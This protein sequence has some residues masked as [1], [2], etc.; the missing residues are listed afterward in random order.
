MCFPKLANVTLVL[1]ILV[2][3]VWCVPTPKGHLH[4]PFRKLPLGS[5][6]KRRSFAEIELLHQSSV[7]YSAVLEM[8]TPSQEVSVVLDTG[9][10][11]LWVASSSNPY[12]LNGQDGSS[13]SNQTYNGQPIEPSLDCDSLGTFDT[14][15]SSSLTDLDIGRFFINYSDGSLADGYWANE[16]MSM[17]G[18]DISDLQ[19]G[20]ADYATAPVGGVL[21]IGFA[22]RESVRGYD[23][24]PGKFYPNFPQVLKKEGV[25]DVVAYSLYLSGEEADC[26]SVLFGAV[27][28]DKYTG[29]LYTFPMVNEYPTVVDKPATLSM[30]LQ[31]IGAKS[32]RNCKSETFTTTK[33]PVLLD[34]GTTFMSAPPEIAS[35][36]ASFIGANY[37]ES[38]GLYVFECPSH[39]DDTEFVFDFGDIKIV[40][41]LSNLVLLPPSDGYCGFGVM[42]APHSM[43][44]GSA[45]LSS[46]YVVYDLDNYQISLAKAK[47]DGG[48]S[49][50]NL[51]KVGKDGHI[52]GA[53][54]A[55]AAAWVTDEPIAVDYDIFEDLVSCEKS[56]SHTTSS[57]TANR[58]TSGQNKAQETFT[59]S[60]KT[61]GTATLSLKVDVTPHSSLDSSLTSSGSFIT[62]SDHD[63]TVSGDRETATISNTKPSPQ[64]ITVI[65]TVTATKTV[66]STLDCSSDD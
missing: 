8:G 17:G 60:Q 38:D 29:S 42:P 19:F 7:Y 4:V 5:K 66:V 24:A 27:D 47:H 57:S 1:F 33:I 25:I 48:S 53:T 62:E 40:V 20:I 13:Y 43:T 50:D 31:A 18:V 30:T 14:G 15:S 12:C 26:G 36:M 65:R 16:K 64:Y 39:D 58:T 2:S 51:V 45:F 63:L 44:L 3:L 52:R 9:S 32:D 6:L 54:K 59:A 34:S 10:A 49:K 23:N 11:D 22:R 21:G 35:E 28:P 41:P 46:A 55:T 61:I 56:V 37:S